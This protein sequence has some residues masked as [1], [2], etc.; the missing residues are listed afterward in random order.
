M[1]AT[2]RRLH[3]ETRPLA[4]DP[5]GPPG[6]AAASGGFPRGVTTGFLQGGLNAFAAPPR[7]DP[8]ASSPD[9]RLVR[10]A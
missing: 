9:N 5:G 7:A 8:P 3:L 2:T 6:N 10:T 4:R 1:V